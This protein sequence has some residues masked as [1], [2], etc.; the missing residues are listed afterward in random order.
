MLYIFLDLK[1]NVKFS[2]QV[3][4]LKITGWRCLEIGRWLD[5]SSS[6][7]AKA[8]NADERLKLATLQMK[9]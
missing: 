6:S 2:I 4:S 1:K 5:G 8:T 3:R 7:G 9:T